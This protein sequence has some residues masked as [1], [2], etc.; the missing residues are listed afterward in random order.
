MTQE[1]SIDS[2]QYACVKDSLVGIQYLAGEMENMQLGQLS[3]LLRAV[4]RDIVKW[5]ES[6]D[7]NQEY[8]KEMQS[9]LTNGE[10]AV[11]SDFISKFCSIKDFKVRKNIINLIEALEIGNE[12]ARNRLN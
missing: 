7:K 9:F 4:C 5:V 8:Y 6:Q 3:N 11:A 1:H 12:K 2:S 10:M